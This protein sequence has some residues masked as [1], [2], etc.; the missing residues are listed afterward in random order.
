MILKQLLDKRNATNISF[1]INLMKSKI[2]Y[3]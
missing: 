3:L 2:L 1:K